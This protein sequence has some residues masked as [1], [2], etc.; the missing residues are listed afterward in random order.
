MLICM[1]FVSRS[2]Y[3]QR[4]AEKW[5]LGCVNPASWFPPAAG[6]EFTQ[7]RVHLLADPCTYI[8]KKLKDPAAMRNYA[9][10]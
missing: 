10:D 7:P 8:S 2:R 3:A 1:N 6:G 5:A 4:S 9:W